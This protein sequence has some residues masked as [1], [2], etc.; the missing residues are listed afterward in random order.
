MEHLYFADFNTREYQ[1]VSNYRAKGK[2][3]LYLDSANF[4][5]QVIEHLKFTFLDV[6]HKLNKLRMKR[7]VGEERDNLIKYI[8][9]M[10]C[11]DMYSSSSRTDLEMYEHYNDFLTSS[12]FREVFDD[13]FSCEEIKKVKE[14]INLYVSKYCEGI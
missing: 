2:S 7:F 10:S 6:F 8:I 12:E 11:S 13:L 1:R 14:A 9:A 3:I 5:P 4:T